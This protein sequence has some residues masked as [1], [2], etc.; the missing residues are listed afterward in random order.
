METDTPTPRPLKQE[1]E[2]ASEA[3]TE[4]APGIL[5]MQLPIDMPGLGHVN[6]YVLSDDR[7][8]A[9]MDPGLPGEASWNALVDRLA[10]VGLSPADVHTVFVTHGHPDHFGLAPRLAAEND[11][12][13][14]IAHEAFAAGWRAA[15]GEELILLDV[16]VEDIV[17]NAFDGTTPWGAT[18]DRPRTMSVD[19]QR[20]RPTRFVRDREPVRL[21]GREMFI[22]HS[23]GHTLDHVC[24]HD[25]DEGILF[26]GDHVLP[27]ITPHISGLGSGRDPLDLFDEALARVGGMT[28]IDLVLPA[29]GHPFTD[30]S[31]RAEA[32]RAH[33][34]ERLLKLRSVSVDIGPA[35]VEALSHHL[36]REAHWGRMAESET[37]AHLEHLRLAGLAERQGEGTAMVYALA[38]P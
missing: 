27:S 37:Y 20:P 6:T 24:L 25:P 18:W 16:D 31:G 30:L 10:S 4:V 23:P 28:G 19:F 11:R 15:D 7:G 36:F 5:R 29:H 21:A 35:T 38:A 17:P 14:L 32:I 26:S 33:H 22:V 13:E 3:V 34:H 8:V 2:P 1:Q 12:L 9:L